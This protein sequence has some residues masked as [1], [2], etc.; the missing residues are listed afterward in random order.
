MRK[1][2]NRK[3]TAEMIR[4]TGSVFAFCFLFSAFS[5]P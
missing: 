3:Q 2:E 1:A 5:Q 4:R